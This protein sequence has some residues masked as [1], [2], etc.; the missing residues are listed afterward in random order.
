MFSSLGGG[1]IG[2]VIGDDGGQR[3][4]GLGGEGGE[5]ARK[6]GGAKTGGDEGDDGGGI[7]HESMMEIF[8]GGWKFD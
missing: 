5:E 3:S 7:S 8:W 4:E 6:K 2:A 1:R